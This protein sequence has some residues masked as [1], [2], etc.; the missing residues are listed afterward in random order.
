MSNMVHVAFMQ[1]EDKRKTAR[2]AVDDLGH[3]F[4]KMLKSAEYIFVH[5]SASPPP[6]SG[7]GRGEDQVATLRGTLDVLRLYSNAPIVIGDAPERG[8]IK[9]FYDAGL[10][11]IVDLYSG[12]YLLDLTKDEVIEGDFARSDGGWLHIRRAKTAVEAPLRISLGSVAD[13]GMGTWVV[14]SR[15]TSTGKSWSKEPFIEALLPEER[16][17]LLSELFLSYPCHVSVRDDI[18]SQQ[19]VLAG[20]DPI[21]VDTVAATIAGLDAHEIAHLEEIASKG[22]WTNEIADID[23]PPGILQELM[24]K[25]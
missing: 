23:V 1:G 24:M 9:A 13:W 12:V 19:S 25:S 15:D 8:A 22:S 6:R 20:L 18:L 7:G 21:A 16:E 5:I 2:K 14:P 4:W 10:E 17:R 11:S 3:D